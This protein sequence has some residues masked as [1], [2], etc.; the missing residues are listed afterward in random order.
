LPAGAREVRLSFADPGYQ[1]GKTITLIALALA[2]AAL[3]AG[4][5]LD[6]RRLVP[7]V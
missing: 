1:S 2:L 5:L 6:R 7:A 3:I 4:V